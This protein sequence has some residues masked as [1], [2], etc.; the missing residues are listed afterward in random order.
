MINSILHWNR[1]AL[2]A[3][4]K[5]FSTDDPTKNPAPQQGGPT[6]TSHHLAIVHIAMYD[7]Y[8]GAKGKQTY[9]NF[10]PAEIP[11]TLSDDGIRIA[12]AAAACLTLIDC[13]SNQKNIFLSAQLDF[14]SM[15]P[16]TA[17]E[18]SAAIAWGSLAA[19]RILEMRENDGSEASDDPYTPSP[20]PGAH[21]P[22]PLNSGQGFLGPLWG[23]VKPFGIIDLV[24]KV[25][26]TRPPKMDSQAYADNFNEVLNKGRDV[27]STRS[28]EETVVGLFWAYDGARNIG[29]PPR[30]YNQ[31]V[32]AIALKHGA[33]EE[34]SARLFAVVNVAM[35]DAGIQAWHEKYLYN[36]WRPVLGIRE[37]E[38]GWGPTGIGDGNVGTMGDPFWVPLGSPPTNQPARTPFTPNF[39]AYPSGHATFGTAAL[40][41]AR[42]ILNLAPTFKFKFVSDELDGKAIGANG[43]RARF[44]HE[45]TIDSA[46][47]ENV[48]SRVFL[49]VHW[50]FDCIEGQKNGSFIATQIAAKFPEM[51]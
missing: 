23:Q 42:Q 14:M 43:V 25:P 9:S 12:V 46:I 17:E 4:R 31:V 29:V 47:A 33:S 32:R 26:T 11:G 36:V 2:E 21:R 7:A 45:F 48:I 18:M 8:F 6:R 51:A 24:K 22:D 19:K 41:A 49:G 3:T 16:T 1:I 30:L 10:L 39:P 37:A 34:Q 44:E 50:R 20:L 40:E 13:Y 5:D 35:A 15:L 38:A 28:P 27:G